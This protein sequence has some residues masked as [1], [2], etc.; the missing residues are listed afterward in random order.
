[1]PD[2]TYFFS[3]AGLKKN[4]K[5]DSRHRILLFLITT[6]VLTGGIF[7]FPE[8]VV[9]Q[10]QSENAA[11]FS[12]TAQPLGSALSAFI[13][14]T[15]WEVGYSAQIMRGKFS[16]PVHG[17]MAPDKALQMLLF[18]TGLEVQL[19]GP[20]TAA[21][22]TKNGT[23]GDE[24]PA[25]ATILNTINVQTGNVS[26]SVYTPYETAGASSHISAEKN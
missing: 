22:V 9:A 6:T 25:G 16:A 21:L 3:C 10:Q 15:G 5:S 12:I 7:V 8:N 13:R 24:V 17:V 1:M 14:T 18:G 4:R 20:S 11:S 2:N 23:D 26:S 19:T